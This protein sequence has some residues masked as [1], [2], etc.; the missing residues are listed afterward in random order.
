MEFKEFVQIL[1]PIIGGSSSQGAFAKTLF[2]AIV[3]EDGQSAVDELTEVTY[4]S[5]FNGS[6]GISRIAKKISPYIETE[7]FV[8]Y[9][10]EFSD[11]TVLRLCDSFREYLPEVNSFNAGTQLADLFL[12]ILKTA[13]GTKEK[14]P[15]KVLRKKESTVHDGL[16]QKIFASGKAVADAWEKAVGTLV[17]NKG[18]MKLNEDALN[19]SDRVLLEKF[20]NH[21]EEILRYCIENDPSGSATRI[22]LADEIHDVYQSWSFELRKIKDKAFRQLVID[23]LKVLNEYTYY[24]SDKFLRLLPGTDSLWFRNESWEEGQQLSNVLQPES[25]KKRC[26]IRDIYQRLYPIPEDGETTEETVEAEV[27]DE[28]AP[29]GAAPE[30]KK[31]T[32]IQH[33]TNVVQNGDNN[34]NVTNNGTMNFNF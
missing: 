23:A 4:R 22:T 25:Y 27:V 21:T 29:S 14:A 34:V 19:E 10:H 20:R 3:T 32:V 31:I 28:D 16:E 24:L 26:E 30:D 5:Y 6:T 13:A 33:Q 15:R 9:V 1:H 7:N 17:D 11:E 18:P 12:S 8:A 2:D